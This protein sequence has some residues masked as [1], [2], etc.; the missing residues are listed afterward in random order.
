MTSYELIHRL[1][2]H[3]FLLALRRWAR[4]NGCFRRLKKMVLVWKTKSLLFCLRY[5]PLIIFWRQ[6]HITFIFLKTTSDD[7]LVQKAYC[8]VLCR[9]H[10]IVYWSIKRKMV[11]SRWNFSLRKSTFCRTCSKII[12][13]RQLPWLPARVRYC[14]IN[15]FKTVFKYSFSISFYQF[16]H[17]CL[18]RRSNSTQICSRLWHHSIRTSF[19]ISIKDVVIATTLLT[20]L[21]D[22]RKRKSQS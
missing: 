5:D 9:Y 4:R 16:R 1:R 2:K 7:L 17:K 19:L 22:V 18:K 12:M 21:F 3:P 20:S 6:N 13:R 15:L 11:H 14:R 8:R 10:F